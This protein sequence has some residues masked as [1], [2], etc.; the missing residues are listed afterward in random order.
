MDRGIEPRRHPVGNGVK[1]GL[2]PSSVVPRKG[3]TGS[4]DGVSF[5]RARAATSR[6][7]ARPPTRLPGGSLRAGQRAPGQ[8]GNA[9]RRRRRR[10]PR[11]RRGG[12]WTCPV[13]RA[14][15][16]REVP[17]PP[18]EGMARATGR[19]RRRCLRL[20]ARGLGIGR[21]RAL[22]SVAVPA[23]TTG[24]KSC[25][26][27]APRGCRRCA[28]ARYA[29]GVAGRRGRDP[30]RRAESAHRSARTSQ[31]P[32]AP[33]DRAPRVGS[34]GWPRY[35]ARL[36][37]ARLL[38]TAS[39]FSTSRPGGGTRGA[40]E[41]RSRGRAPKP[42]LAQS[43]VGSGRNGKSRRARV[44][45]RSRDAV[46][47][48]EHRKALAAG[49]CGDAVASHPRTLWPVRVN[50]RSSSFIVA[51]LEIGG[52]IAKTAGR[53]VLSSLKNRASRHVAAFEYSGRDSAGGTRKP[54]PETPHAAHHP[55][56]SLGGC[57]TRVAAVVARCRASRAAG[58]TRD[59]AIGVALRIA[60]QAAGQ[61]G[62]RLHRH[63]RH[64]RLR[65]QALPRLFDP[66]LRWRPPA[67][68][69]RLPPVP[70]VFQQRLNVGPAPL[71]PVLHRITPRTFSCGPTS[72]PTTAPW[73]T[74]AR[75]PLAAGLGQQDEAAVADDEEA[76]VA[77]FLAA[78][79]QAVVRSAGWRPSPGGVTFI[80]PAGVQSMSLL[81]EPA[82]NKPEPTP[83]SGHSRSG[84][85]CG[86][87]G[88]SAGRI[89]PPHTPTG[90]PSWRLMGQSV[91]RPPSR[92][93]LALEVLPQQASHLSAQA[94]IVLSRTLDEL[95]LRLV[96]DA[97]DERVPFVFRH[98]NSVYEG[99]DRL[100]NVSRSSLVVLAACR[101]DDCGAHYRTA[102]DNAARA[103]RRGRP[104][105]CETCTLIGGTRPSPQAIDVASAGGSSASPCP[106][107][108]AGRRCDGPRLR[109]EW[110]LRTLYDAREAW[111][112]RA[113]GEGV[114]LYAVGLPPW[115]LRRA[116]ALPR[117]H[118]RQR[119]PGRGGTRRAA[120]AT[121]SVLA[122]EV[123]VRRSRQG[124]VPVLPRNAS[125][126]AVP[127]SAARS[128]RAC[129]S[130]AGRTTCAATWPM[131]ACG[132]SWRRCTA[133]A[134]ADRSTSGGS[135]GGLR[136]LSPTPTPRLN[137]PEPRRVAMRSVCPVCPQTRITK[138][139]SDEPRLTS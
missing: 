19:L 68:R 3:T 85:T 92:L 65:L 119:P 8:V 118:A 82:A 123:P 40:P 21:D 104:L 117:R 77:R 100:G 25:C 50:Q 120:T 74:L 98:D 62:N 115:Q 80:R 30:I 14:E 6:H 13:R 110:L 71:P 137:V 18:S 139:F 51:Y 138:G 79:R 34:Y 131:P 36:R 70:R 59:G 134:R 106:S 61:P 66:L 96:A 57:L 48:G 23:T 111:D 10:L 67:L 114:L 125:S 44:D 58:R 78:D 75:R 105:K 121:A 29:D 124:A 33:L 76:D 26:A 72:R 130:A 63:D 81:A 116:R 28:P 103:L 107:F 24:A 4:A 94:S 31:G 122:L 5:E 38:T 97:N 53:S 49:D 89:S 87:R 99:G 20:A 43:V 73:T 88:V 41:S 83:R 17:Q 133:A 126:S 42:C 7:R 136:R 60:V 90:S 54:R 16:R 46:G 12:S 69:D 45:A 129:S 37:T 9:G 109:V 15:G 91:M 127:S 86:M 132:C 112:G 2:T 27:S 55:A 56:C 32:P 11:S 101:C 108:K 1:T 102:V 93:V 64:A 22:P 135:C 113:D 84:R 39:T 35:T 128:V 47:R 52:G 95:Q